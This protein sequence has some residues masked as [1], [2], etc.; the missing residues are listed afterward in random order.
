MPV[1]GGKG[2]VVHASSL[3]SSLFLCVDKHLIHT[4]RINT[5]LQQLAEEFQER[6]HVS[7]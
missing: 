5:A 3:I 6:H 7:F 4:Y 1:L 2:R